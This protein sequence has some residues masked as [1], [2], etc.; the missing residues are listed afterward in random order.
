[1]KVYATVADPR[2][3]LADFPRW[4]ERAE[5]MGF[6]GAIV[7]ESVHDG[8]LAA[9]L[10]LRATERIKVIIGVLVAFPRSPMTTAI[11]A[12]DLQA[13]SGGRFELGLG[14]Q[15]K[16]N[17]V[18]RFGT[19][20]QAPVPRMRDYVGALRAIWRCW[21]DGGGLAFKSD[22]YRFDRMQPF[23]NPGAIAHPEIPILLG[24]VKPNMTRLGGEV[25]DGFMT[26]PTNSSPRYL[27]EVTLPLLAEGCRRAGRAQAAM[28]LIA[29]PLVATGP[30]A[31]TVEKE[32]EHARELMGFLYSTPQYWPSLELYGWGEV[33]PRLHELVRARR[34]NEMKNE[35][36]GA[37]L[38]AFVP[39]GRHAELSGALTR[40]YGGL[41]EG[42]TMRMPADSAYDKQLAKVI[43]SLSSQ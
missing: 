10:A 16:G 20:W 24:G 3:A 27:R 32:I 13:I 9:L 40:W 17:I 26:H 31:K 36:D 22:H 33:G 12:W 4:A 42:I 39:R 23:F 8:F 28:R 29:A 7:P 41:V 34:W 18:G 11:A 38:E 19:E 35:I 2:M 14:S 37:M 25:A 1:M 30:D 43:S 6:Y 5:R 21:Q 15:V